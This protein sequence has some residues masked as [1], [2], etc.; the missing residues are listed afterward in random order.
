MSRLPWDEATQASPE[1]LERALRRAVISEQGLV[2]PEGGER[3]NIAAHPHRAHIGSLPKMTLWDL[4]D[5]WVRKAKEEKFRSNAA[6][7]LPFLPILGPLAILLAL[8]PVG[9][10]AVVLFVLAWVAVNLAF[11]ERLLSLS[12][13]ARARAEKTA[14]VASVLQEIFE[15]RI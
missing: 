7:I 6:A 9:D 5:Q 15:H 13:A 14:E 11:T 12:S 10:G 4:R 1:A 3:V 8:S 2:Y